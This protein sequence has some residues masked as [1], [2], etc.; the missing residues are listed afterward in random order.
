M[1]KSSSTFDKTGTMDK[2]STSFDKGNAWF[3]T[4]GDLVRDNP[5]LTKKD[6]IQVLSQSGFR[7]GI[8]ATLSCKSSWSKYVSQGSSLPIEWLVG[9][10]EIDGGIPYE[11]LDFNKFLNNYPNTPGTKIANALKDYL[12]QESNIQKSQLNA[13]KA[14]QCKSLK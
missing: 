7:Y 1:D 3:A 13:K 5:G 10:D 6:F 11:T 4:I 8:V 9:A 12:N 14:N 2:S